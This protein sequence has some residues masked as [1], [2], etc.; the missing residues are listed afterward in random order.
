MLF[1]KILLILII[2]IILLKKPSEITIFK[3]K[4]FLKTNS[5]CKF[6][7]NQL[8]YIK[9]KKRLFCHIQPTK[10]IKV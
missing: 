3:T 6:P 5:K 9:L 8:I 10:E 4:M 1:N 2:I 7:H